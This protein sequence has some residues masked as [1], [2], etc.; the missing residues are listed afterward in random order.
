M[1]LKTAAGGVK[2]P[3][4]PHATPPSWGGKGGVGQEGVGAILKPYTL[5]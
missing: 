2:V 5:L 4:T 1:A 3:K